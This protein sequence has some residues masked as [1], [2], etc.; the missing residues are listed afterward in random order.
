MLDQAPA[1][2][3]DGTRVYFVAAGVLDEVANDQGDI[4]QPGKPNLYLC[5]EGKGV[6][7]I[8]TLSKNDSPTGGVADPEFGYACG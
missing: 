5:E 1:I 4:A 6:R 8:A 3:E 2:S 7:F